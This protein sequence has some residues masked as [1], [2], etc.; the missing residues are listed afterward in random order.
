MKAI[1]TKI[2]VGTATKPNRIKA[3][4]SDGNSVTLSEGQLLNTYGITESIHSE[5]AARFVANDLA[6]TMGWAK[7]GVK[8]AAGWTKHG[9]VFCFVQ[10][11]NKS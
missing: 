5:Y 7:P 1:S 9:W 10:S 11:E 6:I 8:L 3:F 2:L 4:D